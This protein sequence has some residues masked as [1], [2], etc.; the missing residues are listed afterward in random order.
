METK[1]K[2]KR[3]QTPH[4]VKPPTEGAPLKYED[5][6]A[7]TSIYRIF[8]QLNQARTHLVVDSV[9][10]LVLKKEDQTKQ[11]FVSAGGAPPFW[12][13][14][15]QYSRMRLKPQDGQELVKR[16]DDRR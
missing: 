6:R 4:I 9:R 16:K 3:P 2:R 11:I 10:Y 12:M 1:P 13:D 5:I 14:V 15:K 7:N 8:R